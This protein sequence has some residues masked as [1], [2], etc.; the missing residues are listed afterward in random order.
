[1]IGHIVVHRARGWIRLR[2]PPSREKHVL[3]VRRIGRA[4]GPVRLRYRVPRNRPPVNHI[5][6]WRMRRSARASVSA[7]CMALH[8]AQSVPIVSIAVRPARHSAIIF[9]FVR[10]GGAGQVLGLVAS[11]KLLGMGL[12]NKYPH[13]GVCLGVAWR[14]SGRYCGNSGQNRRGMSRLDINF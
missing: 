7:L 6:R 9:N 4:P 14:N 12:L 11:E 13:R 8:H 2:N 3:M 1:M 5:H 10:I